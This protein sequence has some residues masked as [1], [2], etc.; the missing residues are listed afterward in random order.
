[1]QEGDF[2][3]CHCEPG[4]ATDGLKQCGKC[5]DPLMKY[6]EMCDKQ[7]SWVLN[8]SY[9]CKDLETLMPKD[10]YMN[11]DDINTHHAGRIVY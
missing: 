9:E 3:R 4:F 2:A 5:E 7:R 6:P 10:L 11:P 8:N 1:M